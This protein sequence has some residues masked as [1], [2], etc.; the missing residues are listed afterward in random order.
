LREGLTAY[1]LQIIL[2]L[3]ALVAL[4]KDWKEYNKRS[5]KWGK[6]VRGFLTVATL[7]LIVFSVMDTRSNRADAARER[8]DLK[9]QITQLR[10]DARSAN[11]GFRQSFAVLYDKFSQLQ[12]K[13]QNGELLKQNATLIQ[14]IA[15]TK[16]ELLSTEAKLNQPKVKPLAS[17]HVNDSR[18]VPITET[19]IARNG[20]TVSVPIIIYN[21]SDVTGLSGSVAVT[22]CQECS[23]A[24]EP[25]G[26]VKVAGAPDS[27]RNLDFQR[28]FPQSAMQLPTL[29]VAVPLNLNRFPIAVRIACENCAPSDAQ[30][31]WVNIR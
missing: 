7:L 6:F 25:T 11:D 24:S 20:A 16:K 13:V 18:E 21:P 17:F 5:K 29:A 27:Q 30:I 1:G 31:L 26:F 23:F 4:W 19:T 3:I 9:S 22:P 14:E 2:G 8:G 12:S 10:D 28:I 15:E